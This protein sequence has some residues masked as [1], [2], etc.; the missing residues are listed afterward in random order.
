VA[1]GY[2]NSTIND[3]GTTFKVDFEGGTLAFWNI[4]KEINLYHML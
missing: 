4:E 2:R 1:D 3:I